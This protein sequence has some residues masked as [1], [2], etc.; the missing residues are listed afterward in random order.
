MTE[1]EEKIINETEKI[2]F[3]E[4]CSISEAIDKAKEILLE[5]E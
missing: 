5:K 3:D 2:Y 4:G 1:K